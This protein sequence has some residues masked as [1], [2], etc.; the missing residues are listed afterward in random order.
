MSGSL[1]L[2]I[3]EK[4]KK[5][6]NN[7]NNKKRGYADDDTSP[8]SEH[9]APRRTWQ[10]AGLSDGDGVLHC[11]S[12]STSGICEV[13]PSCHYYH[14]PLCGHFMRYKNCAFL[15]TELGCKFLHP[16]NPR[17]QPHPPPPP[18][19]QQQQR[20]SPND[21]QRKLEKTISDLCQ[22]HQHNKVLDIVCEEIQHMAPW[23]CATLL[24]KFAKAIK[25]TRKYTNDDRVRRLIEHIMYL[26]TV[27]EVP[28]H[29]NN[30]P[31]PFRAPDAS[32][33]LH[34][35]A[36]LGYPCE[37]FMQ[38][39]DEQSD[40]LLDCDTSNDR[41]KDWTRTA[42]SVAWAFGAAQFPAPRFFAGLNKRSCRFIHDVVAQRNA[43]DL[44]SALHGA[45]KS[46]IKAE[47]VNELFAAAA[48]EQ[49]AL[50]LTS[51]IGK[52]TQ[53]IANILIAFSGLKFPAPTLCSAVCSK[54]AEM[55][56]A[57]EADN[58]PETL[59]CLLLAFQNSE[60]VSCH[61]YG[62]FYRRI[63]WFI[64]T[65]GTRELTSAV[66][67]CVK[68]NYPAPRLFAGLDMIG[69]TLI[70]EFMTSKDLR[71][72]ALAALCWSFVTAKQPAPNILAAVNRNAAW[73]VNRTSPGELAQLSNAFTHLEVP[74][75]SFFEAVG[76]NASS[77]VARCVATGSEGGRDL[78]ML[79]NQ[80]ARSA[81]DEVSNVRVG[82]LQA[83]AVAL[84]ARSDWIMD[85]C[86]VLTIRL[87]LKAV[88]VA[89]QRGANVTG[90]FF[91]SINSRADKV[92]TDIVAS[93]DWGIL[94]EFMNS[95]AGAGY[96]KAPKFFE[97]AEHAA[98]L[99]VQ[100]C[101]NYGEEG[102]RN[103]SR[104]LWAC[105]KLRFRAPRLFAAADSRAT[106]WLVS[107]SQPLHITMTVRA[108]SDAGFSAPNLLAALTESCI[109]RTE[110]GDKLRYHV[111]RIAMQQQNRELSSAIAML[112]GERELIRSG[113]YKTVEVIDVESGLTERT[114]VDG[115]KKGANQNALKNF[116]E[117]CRTTTTTLTEVKKEKEE[118]REDLEDSQETQQYQVL[119][120][121]R[122]QSKIDEL[123]AL[124]LA[125]GADPRK[126]QEIRERH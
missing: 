42:S 24:N 44:S 71:L 101:I 109:E 85:T 23:M 31:F 119:H 52:E 93:R 27:D 122:L 21:Y 65:A 95:F 82:S 113:S 68:A 67:S 54:A 110:R 69:D 48:G 3:E 92:L 106:A 64:R 2:N 58:K 97:A 36:K 32:L 50:W 46:G 105:A 7:N 14:Q 107:V 125:A 57:I 41:V 94:A 117:F 80:M 40:W 19:Q 35:M 79:A 116:S 8:D 73:F 70:T 20:L 49:V 39:A 47:V 102:A 60:R 112:E 11:A 104:S 16:T 45:Y 96:N 10:S 108:F 88:S 126:V 61:I 76:T 121:D 29:T 83:L 111:G 81:L 84:E 59:A 30:K 15:R 75:D 120:T 1:E 56:S 77:I 26:F 91:D 9:H 37:Q 87:V 74:A 98:E 18:Q 115:S 78:G 66:L 124:A 89:V 86:D 103:L 5:K 38:A 51:A 25:K 6:K 33:L 114:L 123:A 53:S 90:L 62:E 99:F 22:Q 63:E 100:E 34:S 55:M 12:H 43:Q 28:H 4:K 17:V 72:S 13:G 118:L